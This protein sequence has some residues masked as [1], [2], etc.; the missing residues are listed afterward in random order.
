ME[1][2]DKGSIPLYLFAKAPRPGHVKTR[3]QPALS[4]HR[5]AELAAMMLEET[6]LKVSECWPGERILTVAPDIGHPVLKSLARCHGFRMEA[7]IQGDLGERMLHVLEQGIHRFGG[8]AVMGSDI[9]HIPGYVINDAH[10]QIM[11]G[12]N[13]IGP[14]LDGGFYLLGLA[15]RVEGIF[16]SVDWS[17][18]S[19]LYRVQRNT[20]S[21]DILLSEHPLLR[22]IDAWDDLSWLADRDARYRQ[23]LTP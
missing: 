23:F 2:N 14:S 13:V 7:Q 1:K 17:T 22:D 20:A 5:S 19:V 11:R 4:E 18:G 3:L 6:M 12:V 9:P 8:A 21:S 16:D 10:G 15:A